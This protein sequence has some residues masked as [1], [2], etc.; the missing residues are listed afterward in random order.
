MTY[1]LSVLGW[2]TLPRLGLARFP[3]L[4]RRFD[5]TMKIRS[6]GRTTPMRNSIPG[7]LF[8]AV[9]VLG[10]LWLSAGQ[11]FPGTSGRDLDAPIINEFLAANRAGIAD[12]DG[13]PEDWIEI[14][15]PGRRAVN[16][17]GWS[18]TDDPSRPRKWTFPGVALG[19]HAYLL[20]FASGKN[21]RPTQP[22]SELHTNFKLSQR[23][24]FL[25][26]YDVLGQ[27]ASTPADPGGD[28]FPEQF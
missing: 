9:I 2:K 28:E 18:L 17:A 11:A 25:G 12:Q 6:S 15:N 16:L 5:F 8:L 13:D 26:L 14:Y 7:C 22:G 10:G 21:R 3:K 1:H 24:E 4:L 20:V 23:G 27:L 19:S